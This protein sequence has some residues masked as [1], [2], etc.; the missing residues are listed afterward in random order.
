MQTHERW[1]RSIFW[2]S[3]SLIAELCF[4]A[5]SRSQEIYM[6]LSSA[7]VCDYDH[8]RSPNCISIWSQTITE[9][10][11]I[12]VRSANVCDQ[13][14]TRLK[15]IMLKN[16]CY[17]DTQWQMRPERPSIYAF[18]IYGNYRI[19]IIYLHIYGPIIDPHNDLLSV[20]SIAQLVEHCTVITEVR[21]R[22][23]V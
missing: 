4:H 19:I 1:I 16:K 11:A 10:F 8:R 2:P 17:F 22:I 3:R 23:P 14:E 15:I 13:M 5:I 18:Q 12:S 21:V 6:V 9:R 20:G 7:M